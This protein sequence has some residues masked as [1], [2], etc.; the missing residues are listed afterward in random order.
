MPLLFAGVIGLSFLLLMVVFLSVVVAAK[1][2]I[3][4]CFRSVRPTA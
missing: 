4:N 3:M 1:A 2:A